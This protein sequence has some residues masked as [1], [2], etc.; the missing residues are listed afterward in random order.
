VE[1][2]VIGFPAGL[3]KVGDTI[4][5]REAGMHY[6]DGMGTY[7]R[8]GR[9]LLVRQATKEESLAYHLSLPHQSDFVSETLSKTTPVDYFEIPMD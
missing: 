5:L 4:D 1:A 9:M 2:V 3:F 6:R 7:H 8:E